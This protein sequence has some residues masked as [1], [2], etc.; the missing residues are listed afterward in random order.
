MERSRLPVND[1][2]AVSTTAGWRRDAT[3]ML[4]LFALSLGLNGIALDWGLP[5][6]ERAAFYPASID[7][8]AIPHDRE[9]LYQTTPYQS[10]HPDEGALLTALSAMDPGELD[11]DPD[12][13]LYPTL[14]IY[15][16]GAALGVGKALGWIDLVGS[17]QHYVDYPAAMARIYLV[18]RALAALLASL[19][20]VLLYATA[21]VLFDRPVALWAGLFLALTP[22]WVR[23]AHFMLVT[24]PSTTWMI[25]CAFLA[26]LGWRRGSLPIVLASAMV[27]GLAAS[28]KYPAG[29]IA[30]LPCLVSL[31]LRPWRRWSIPALAL[32][33]T[34][35]FLLGTPYALLSFDRFI[36]DMGALGKGFLPSQVSLWA[37]LPVAQGTALALLSLAGV[38]LTLARLGE[39]RYQLVAAWLLAGGAY[40]MLSGYDL[41]RILISLLPPLA[42]CAAL[43]LAALLRR[44]PGRGWIRRLGW[45]SAL[46][47][48]LWTAGY[49]IDIVGLMRGPDVRDRVA[50][51]IEDNIRPGQSVGIL[52]RLYCDMPPIDAERYRLVRI[53]DAGLDAELPVVVLS[54]EALF[55][56]ELQ[57]IDLAPL[58]DHRVV[59]FGQRPRPLWSWPSRNVPRDWSLTFLDLF[60]YLAPGIET[61]EAGE[62]SGRR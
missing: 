30:I 40:R 29:A 9:R 11:F 42:L 36:A 35:G 41:I 10:Y 25:A 31:Y 43:A 59:R 61:A 22:L 48:V 8:D 26:S 16:T 50:R 57:G 13:F 17:R 28:T 21:R 18:G 39:V 33:G 62:K 7:W 54:S 2:V 6:A 60:I 14:S 23:N 37:Q 56:M 49:S 1:A 19:G 12:F 5:H 58:A 45:G 47:T 3:W 32:C 55:Y 51:W 53:Y 34:G 52:N 15:L 20:V 24:V 27:A 44:R 46:V 38:G 4:A